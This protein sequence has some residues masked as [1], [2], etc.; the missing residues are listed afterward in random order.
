MTKKEAKNKKGIF[1]I[2]LLVSIVMSIVFLCIS[3]NTYNTCTKYVIE[4]NAFFSSADSFDKTK[5]NY[6]LNKDGD[7]ESLR[8]NVLGTM[9]E[10]SEN[11]KERFINRPKEIAKEGGFYVYY[12][13]KNPTNAFIPFFLKSKNTFGVVTS[14]FEIAFLPSVFLTIVVS[15]LKFRKKMLTN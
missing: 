4:E 12:D 2:V 1:T 11:Q 6:T 15:L 5:L 3:Y 14:I 8:Y 10:L 13:T 9:L 7:V